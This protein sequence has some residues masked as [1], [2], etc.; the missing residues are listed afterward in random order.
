V[1]YEF[2]KLLRKDPFLQ[3]LA[4]NGSFFLVGNGSFLPILVGNGSFLTIFGGKRFF[5]NNFWGKIFR[6]TKI[7]TTMD[8]SDDETVTHSLDEHDQGQDTETPRFQNPMVWTVV[9]RWTTTQL[10]V[11]S[12]LVTPKPGLTPR[13]YNPRLAGGFRHWNYD[14]IFVVVV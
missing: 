1:V 8:L 14:P 7:F 3:F 6:Y 10:R 2:N 12:D 4:G 9:T 5:L 11:L 13:I